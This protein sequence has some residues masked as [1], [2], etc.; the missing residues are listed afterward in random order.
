MRISNGYKQFFLIQ[1]SLELL[2]L[3]EKNN[4]Y[5]LTKRIEKHQISNR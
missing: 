4:K 1:E 3:L 5:I 2:L